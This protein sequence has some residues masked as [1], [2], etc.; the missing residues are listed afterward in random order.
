VAMAGDK[1]LEELLNILYESDN[2]A[3]RDDAAQALADFADSPLAQ[4]ALIAALDSKRLDESLE[5]TCAESL[6]TIWIRQG[7]APGSVLARVSGVPREVIDAYL[8]SSGTI[9]R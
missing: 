9:V 5:R 4:A 7:Y 8:I 1:N 6:A 2:D 3:W